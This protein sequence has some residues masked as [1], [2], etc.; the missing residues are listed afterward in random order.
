MFGIA[1]I[2]ES[3]QTLEA[4]YGIATTGGVDYQVLEQAIPDAEKFY[5]LAA[6]RNRA[7]MTNTLERMKKENVHV[8]ALVT[9]GFHSEGISTLMDQ[10]KLSYLVVMPKFDEKSAD[11]PYIAILTCQPKAYEDKFKDSDFTIAAQEML[12]LRNR[13]PGGVYEPGQVAAFCQ[14]AFATLAVSSRLV[15]NDPVFDADEFLA[16]YA[17]RAALMVKNNQT[18]LI[19]VEEL[20]R[21]V[22]TL[23]P[24]NKDRGHYK[25]R[26][27]T[28][29][30]VVSFAA[31]LNSDGGLG[32][33]E[34]VEADTEAPPAPLKE[35]QIEPASPSMRA[36]EPVMSRLIE[37]AL[38][39]AAKSGLEPKSED[40]V[41]LA[42]AMNADLD[43]QK[44]REI[45]TLVAA[46][47]TQT[48]PVPPV[49][50][51]KK[52]VASVV[53]DEQTSAASKQAER[54]QTQSDQQKQASEPAPSRA[55]EP[56]IPLTAKERLEMIKTLAAVAM[57]FFEPA[58]LAGG[59]LLDNYYNFMMKGP[60]PAFVG[61]VVYW[62]LLVVI[63]FAIAP[64]LIAAEKIFH[65][66]AEE[67]FGDRE[68]A[69]QQPAIEQAPKAEATKQES[70]PDFFDWAGAKIREQALRIWFV[71]SVLLLM[72]ASLWQWVGASP[73]NPVSQKQMQPP[74]ATIPQDQPEKPFGPIYIDEKP[75][76][77][78]FPALAR[79]TA[80]LKQG[81]LPKPEFESAKPPDLIVVESPKEVS[82][83]KIA[84]ERRDYWK[85]IIYVSEVCDNGS[86][87]VNEF[88]NP[89]VGESR[90]TLTRIYTTALAN[91]IRK[92]S[93][94]P[95][96]RVFIEAA[97][98]IGELS[99]NGLA[100]KDLMVE[101]AKAEDGSR[102]QNILFCEM[103][104]I[105]APSGSFLIMTSIDA[106]GQGHLGW[107]AGKPYPALCSVSGPS[108]LQKISV[109][110]RFVYM[111]FGTIEG[112]K[113]DVCPSGALQ[114][115]NVIF[116]DENFL[117]RQ[118]YDAHHLARLAKNKELL[119]NMDPMDRLAVLFC[120]KDFA[121]MSLEEVRK[122]IFLDWSTHEVW[123]WMSA[124]DSRSPV[125]QSQQEESAWT[126][127]VGNS[128]A[129]FY[130]ITQCARTSR[131]LLKSGFKENVEYATQEARA[132][133]GIY[134][135]ALSERLVKVPA[136]EGPSLAELATR[137]QI[138]GYE[139]RLTEILGAFDSILPQDKAKLAAVAR[140]FFGPSRSKHVKWQV[141]PVGLRSDI[142]FEMPLMQEFVKVTSGNRRLQRLGSMRF[143]EMAET[144]QSS[145]PGWSQQWLHQAL[146]QALGYAGP[147]ASGVQSG[148]FAGLKKS[149]RDYRS[150]KVLFP[151]SG[152]RLSRR[153]TQLLNFCYHMAV[154][155][156]PRDLRPIDTADLTVPIK[157]R[158]SA[159]SL[160]STTEQDI[161]HRPS[162]SRRNRYPWPT[163]I[164]PAYLVFALGLAIAAPQCLIGYCVMT[165]AFVVISKIPNMGKK[166]SLIFKA[167][168][169]SGF[170]LLALVL[171]D[172]V[173]KTVSRRNLESGQ[174]TQSPE[175]MSLDE[176][177]KDSEVLRVTFDSKTSEEFAG[178]GNP[179]G[180]RDA[181]IDLGGTKIG[182]GRAE[183]SVGF[184][185]KESPPPDEDV[186]PPHKEKEKPNL[187]VGTPGSQAG[188]DG[189]AQIGQST[190]DSSSGDELSAA[191]EV[192]KKNGA[193]DTDTSSGEPL[194]AGQKWVSTFLKTQ[195]AKA[196]AAGP[197]ESVV[198]AQAENPAVTF[199]G[200]MQK[201][202]SGDR[203][204]AG[205]PLIDYPNPS[206][207][208][209]GQGLSSKPGAGGTDEGLAGMYGRH[210][211]A[212]GGITSG[213]YGMTFDDSASVGAEK[214]VFFQA[215]AYL[216][217]FLFFQARH[218]Q[219]GFAC[220]CFS[221]NHFQLIPFA[222]C[223]NPMAIQ[224]GLK[225]FADSPSG[226]TDL[227]NSLVKAIESHKAQMRTNASPVPNLEIIYTDT[228]DLLRPELPALIRDAAAKG[229]DIVIINVNPT[230]TQK[231][232]RVV[233]L[234]NYPGLEPQKKTEL[235][236]RVS[237]GLIAWK[238]Q[239]N[240]KPLPMDEEGLWKIINVQLNA[241][242]PSG[243]RLAGME[244][245]LISPVITQAEG[246]ALVSQA[247][248]LRQIRE[249]WVEFRR[250]YARFLR[251]DTLAQLKR[252]E[253]WLGSRLLQWHQRQMRRAVERMRA[254]LVKPTPSFERL[255]KLQG[256]LSDSMGSFARWLTER[257]Y[258]QESNRV[259]QRARRE[260]EIAGVRLGQM[261]RLLPV[262][263]FDIR[264]AL[265]RAGER[266]K[267]LNLVKVLMRGTGVVMSVFAAINTAAAFGAIVHLIRI[268]DIAA[269]PLIAAD[270][271]AGASYL[272]LKGADRRLQSG[273][274][275]PAAMPAVFGKT[276]GV[277]FANEPALES[278]KDF[279]QSELVARATVERAQK[280]TIDAGRSIA[281]K[282]VA[283]GTA[284]T[285]RRMQ[286]EPARVLTHARVAA[287]HVQRRALGALRQ[288][289]QINIIADSA[290]FGRVKDE[291]LRALAQNGQRLGD[292]AIRRVED[293]NPERIKEVRGSYAMF[294]ELPFLSGDRMEQTVTGIIELNAKRGQRLRG[295][296]EKLLGALIEFF[297]VSE[298]ELT[299]GQRQAVADAIQAALVEGLSPYHLVLVGGRHLEVRTDDGEAGRSPQ[300]ADFSAQMKQAERLSI[301]ARDAISRHPAAVNTL[302]SLCANIMMSPADQASKTAAVL[303]IFSVWRTSL[304]RAQA[305][306]IPAMSLEEKLA[307]EISPVTIL[308]ERGLSGGP[309]VD[310]AKARL[311]QWSRGQP[312]E[313]VETIEDEQFCDRFLASP[314]KSA[315]FLNRLREEY[316]RARN[317]DASGAIFVKSAMSVADIQNYYSAV[318]TARAIAVSRS[319]RRAGEPAKDKVALSMGLAPN[320]NGKTLNY[321]FVVALRVALS[322]DRRAV[323]IPNLWYDAVSGVYIYLPIL[324]RENV[325]ADLEDARAM[326][327]AVQSSA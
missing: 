74:A 194:P 209:G 255:E 146:A 302:L 43:P 279:Q 110:G 93:F 120:E 320:W 109:D 106:N 128:G 56:V 133:D 153:L 9:G 240:Q 148:Y 69:G 176:T 284:Q 174:S 73:P 310:E 170:V 131:T 124:K 138:D 297:K 54:P 276:Q 201:M 64:A 221:E 211:G 309:A 253:G 151:F 210:K 11:R 81:A 222:K 8:A 286:T 88:L 196:D 136:V 171:S 48:N 188:T 232:Q 217:N 80:K 298:E 254:D 25:I 164:F 70:A 71:S 185:E 225:G 231:I 42:R 98:D 198:L 247:P 238:S 62:V 94:A 41:R 63:P 260:L 277:R 83:W 4:K 285:T 282:Q 175:Q 18:P 142:A 95:N 280:K 233:T 296:Q 140:G 278:Q 261:E 112:A 322:D 294:V 227:I 150:A 291:L 137:R 26:F 272:F 37:R 214:A 122:A 273:L 77:E 265:R 17:A 256:A 289:V 326:A 182:G 293:A 61:S 316:A 305:Q 28:A 271:L 7:L 22:R 268:N 161:G 292:F 205:D 87:K 202:D 290:D 33:V 126:Q 323:A 50:A 24:V 34:P 264:A 203:L 96:A 207:L 141:L 90:M 59:Y 325:T 213:N 115:E 318:V 283:R 281:A 193:T 10:E 180:H 266:F 156:K 13:L 36:K 304:V 127:A 113:A 23:R 147:E 38:E 242:K 301:P 29:Q 306:T 79:E 91:A 57:M 82:F 53:A 168:A 195:K 5:A 51:Q 143:A 72:G 270:V 274:G 163:W 76:R 65:K 118:A 224:K 299:A 248:Q 154:P 267:S 204:Q 315:E 160:V 234:N 230:L 313:I 259:Y 321:T 252:E 178:F 303:S 44:A 16:Q 308:V 67:D 14:K 246:Q 3:V 300:A 99:A 243:G 55:G 172:Q 237:I 167:M 119:Q 60:K 184:G 102:E 139:A 49:A 197:A 129:T 121:G 45:L 68:V 275:A 130:T 165:A 86:S 288:K 179:W 187:E 104:T 250:A 226:G 287:A 103:Q 111:I 241:G 228:Q 295:I 200:I 208:T 314:D 199:Q 89:A 236:V 229:L 181:V 32:E 239:F 117:S 312:V 46:R 169:L 6:R 101:Y 152:A 84:A 132:I 215:G 145:F 317:K 12:D 85:K 206:S 19:G 190:S 52:P 189:G 27:E 219:V 1:Q 257:L 31:T 262:T 311:R 220:N 47:M 235:L 192:G 40:L 258:A 307:L 92:G 183:N 149:T 15:S 223:R 78:P 263:R 158:S 108:G 157:T 245:Q 216:T 116:V 125:P 191:K 66:P 269:M 162:V 21:W 177:R 166:E 2:R 39:K 134:Q 100:L 58:A 135:A 144:L 30:G 97:K 218:P 107:G 20:T 155:Q 249:K 327:F 244:E 173:N 319:A 123:H 251:S 186:S 212:I 35:A 114:M 75:E 159:V 105:F 324:S